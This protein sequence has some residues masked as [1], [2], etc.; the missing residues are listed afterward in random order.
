[1][2]LYFIPNT[3]NVILNV[4]GSERTTINRN[5]LVG[6]SKHDELGDGEENHVLEE[7]R[8]GDINSNQNKQQSNVSRVF[9]GPTNDRQR[10]IVEAFRHAWTGYKKF[11][12]G[13]DNLK[14]ISEGY[15]EWFGLGLTIVDSIDT[16]YIMGLKEGISKRDQNDV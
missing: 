2:V 4:D 5:V 6:E 16:I 14:P 1:M 9:A 8:F 13:H 10:A 11:A 15:S 12:W 3:D 7:P